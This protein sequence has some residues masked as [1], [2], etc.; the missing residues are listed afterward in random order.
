LRRQTRVAAE[1]YWR[2]NVERSLRIAFWAARSAALIGADLAED[3]GRTEVEA[4]VSVLVPGSGVE[5][6]DAEGRRVL[7]GSARWLA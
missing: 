6:R 2:A 5:A 7:L 4:F 1:P 3:A